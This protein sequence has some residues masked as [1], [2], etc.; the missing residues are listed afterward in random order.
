MSAPTST[1][2]SPGAFTISKDSRQP[3]NYIIESAKRNARKEESYEQGEYRFESIWDHIISSQCDHAEDD[4]DGA[5]KCKICLF[6][7]EL[8]LLPH[9]PELLFP[10][11]ELIIRWKNHPNAQISFTA[12]EAL[13]MVST[14]KLP[15]FQVASAATWQE[16]RKGLEEFREYEKPFD[17]TYTTEY[18]G[19]L[20]E[21]HES[22]TEDAIDMETLK[23]QDP[24]LFYAQNVLYED[25]LHDH[26]MAQYSARI[27]VMPTCFFVLVRVCDTRVFGR[28]HETSIIREWSLREAK[29]ET[30]KH[31]DNDVI[32]D[33]NQIWT[34]LPIVKEH[35]A[36]LAPL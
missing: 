32:N 26:G 11:N 5:Q 2:H 4:D 7:R 14:S 36:K 15:D 1:A 20:K 23:R 9:H 10:D 17:W 35:T 3:A 12:L 28:T 25:E 33:P 13:K 24:I 18:A 21:V 30:L 19:T 8:S 22:E 6:G 34:H 29:M 31:L 16:A 27:R